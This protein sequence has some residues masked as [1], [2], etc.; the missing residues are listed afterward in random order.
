MAVIIIIAVVGLLIY[1][2]T[3][4]KSQQTFVD[5]RQGSTQNSQTNLARQK[6]QSKISSLP[7]PDRADA[8]FG[9][10]MPLIEDSK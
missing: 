7:F 4:K 8:I 3:R 5:N 1:F 6:F 9:T 2:G 10:L